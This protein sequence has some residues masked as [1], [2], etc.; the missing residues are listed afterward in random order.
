MKT[1]FKLRKM[2]NS[3]SIDHTMYRSMIGSLLYFTATRSN[4]LQA[5]CMVTRFQVDPKEVRVQVVKRIFRY[6]KGTME[7]DLRFPKGMDFNL[8]S[9]LDADYVG[10]INDKK[11]TNG[12]AFYLGY[13]LVSWHSKKYDS[14]SLS[15]IDAEYIVATSY[16][17]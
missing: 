12:S 11:S 10:C 3:P 14:I 13:N 4:I 15:T 2:D 6:M 7:F 17:T 16:C 5:I 8:F 1:T 9:Y